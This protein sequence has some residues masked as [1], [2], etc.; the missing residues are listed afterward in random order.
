MNTTLH[1]HEALLLRSKAVFHPR[2]L[3]V[4]G[5]NLRVTDTVTGS[6]M[7]NAIPPSVALPDLIKAGSDRMGNVVLLAEMT[8]QIGIAKKLPDVY[9]LLRELAVEWDRH[10]ALYPEAAADGWLGL[11]VNRAK[12]LRNEIDEIAN[13]PRS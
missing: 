7:D 3:S 11:L 1:Q 13:A 8:R 9:A 12:V 2:Q 6:Y 10:V 4:A 5:K